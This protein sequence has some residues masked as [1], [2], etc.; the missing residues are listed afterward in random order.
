[1]NLAN[2]GMTIHGTASNAQL[3]LP[4]PVNPSKV[5]IWQHVTHAHMHA[6]QSVA[7]RH[8][9]ITQQLPRHVAAVGMRAARAETGGAHEISAVQVSGGVHGE[10]PQRLSKLALHHARPA[11]GHDGGNEEQHAVG[12]LLDGEDADVGELKDE[13]ADEHLV[14]HLQPGQALTQ[15]CFSHER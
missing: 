11:D 10:E 3:G 15:V 2:P 12:E 9:N 14:V 4:L 6:P 1:M 13:D 5:V 8:R 7:E